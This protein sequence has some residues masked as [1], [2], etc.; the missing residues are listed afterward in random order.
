M[1]SMVIGS[2]I[3]E[4]FTQELQN[5]SSIVLTQHIKLR[6]KQPPWKRCVEKQRIE[7]RTDKLKENNK[8]QS[9]NMTPPPKKKDKYKI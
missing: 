8:E 2:R 9:G 5:Y 4:P 7:I 1:K 6:P 3:S